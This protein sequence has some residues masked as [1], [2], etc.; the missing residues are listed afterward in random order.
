MKSVLKVMGFIAIL[1][2][3]LPALSNAA[4]PKGCYIDPTHGFSIYV[5]SDWTRR[6][7]RQAEAYVYEFRSPRPNTFVQLRIFP[8]APGG[9]AA[10]VRKVFETNTFPSAKR[11]TETGFTLNGVPGG[12][13]TYRMTQNG[14]SVHVRAFYAVYRGRANALWSAVPETAPDA[15]R[16]EVYGV[17]RTFSPSGEPLAPGTARPSRM[18]G[19]RKARP[20]GAL[21]VAALSVGDRLMD[22]FRVVPRER[23]PDAAREIFAVFQWR[24]RG[25]NAPLTMRW[26]NLSKKR[27]FQE[28]SVGVATGTGGWGKGSIV[29]GDLRWPLGQWAVDILSGGTLL[30]RELFTI[31]PQ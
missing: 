27:V 30:K 9:D 24:G 20:S 28:Y 7:F 29:R 16:D 19:A 23:I 8:A 5:P 13:A 22:D 25:D 15:A 3:T 18:D 14:V 21:E 12:M 26:T 1:A 4:G 6:S 17:F 31:V 10:S 2:V 11:L